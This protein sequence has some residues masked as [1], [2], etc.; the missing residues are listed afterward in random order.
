MADLV[1]KPKKLKWDT[2]ITQTPVLF[3]VSDENWD[4]FYDFKC[5]G[6]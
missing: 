6:I 2:Y 1:E 3:L 5:Q 4:I